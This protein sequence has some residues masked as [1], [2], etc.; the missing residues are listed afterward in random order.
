MK[1][2]VVGCAHG[3]LDTLYAAI[4]ELEQRQSTTV[5]LIICPGDFQAVRNQSDLACMACPPKYRD[6]RSFWKYYNGSAVAPIPTIF[7]GGNHEASNYLQQLP[8]GGLVAPNIYYLGNAG[9]IN[10]GGLRIA[11]ISGVYTER[12]YEKPRFEKPPYPKNQIKSV[13]HTRKED[14]Q[15]LLR[16]RRPVDIFVSHDWP[17]G[18][19][20]HGNLSKLLSAKPFLRHEIEN[21]TFGNP[22]TA[23]LL[24]AIQPPFWFAAHMH[25]KF[26]AIVEHEQG[27]RTRFLALDK[28]LPRRDFVQ[29]LDVPVQSSQTQAIATREEG[30]VHLDAE[31]LSILKTGKDDP[32]RT[33]PVS[34]EEMEALSL[35]MTKKGITQHIDLVSD[36]QTFAATHHR[37]SQKGIST[38]TKL[39]YH[40]YTLKLFDCLDIK[41]DEFEEY[42]KANSMH[43]QSEE[44][45]EH[46]VPSDAAVEENV[47]K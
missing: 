47:R 33:T 6:M 31:W 2:A 9:V 25:V 19:W 36:F 27:V 13:Y 39:E 21:G 4:K 18:I 32:H 40:P 11:G 14:V 1:V 41:R 10:F 45:M 17:R 20:R 15:R 23:E 44:H 12:D 8:L 29:L 24:R 26:A 34:I 37:L 42:S 16:L 7:V 28:I 22:G 30:R 3:E 35:S 46:P 38:P 5:D 43:L